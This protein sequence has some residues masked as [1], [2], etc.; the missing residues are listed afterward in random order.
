[1]LLSYFGLLEKFRLFHKRGVKNLK[2]EGIGSELFID[3]EFKN[4]I[5]VLLS[6]SLNT[7]RAQLEFKAN[8][9]A[10]EIDFD[11]LVAITNVVDEETVKEETEKK[12]IKAA[13]N[14]NRERITQFLKGTINAR[15]GKYNYQK[16]EGSDFKGTFTFFNNELVIKGSTNAMGGRVNL[17]GKGFFTRKPYV[18]AK[19][20]CRK[21]DF[22]E[23]F[24]QFEDFG[25]KVL[26]YKNIKG[27]VNGKIA[28]DVFWDENGQFL[29]E[30]LRVL[31]DISIDDGELVNF[32]MLYDFSNYVKIQ[33][34]R[35]IKF[36]NMRNWLEVKDGKVIIPSMFIQSN[37]L[38]MTVS[39]E[40][41]F[42]NAMNYNIKINAG[43]VLLNKFKKY[44][45]RLR[46]QEAKRQGWFNLYYRQS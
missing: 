40:H 31:G 26:S 34:L 38:N 16:V 3:G 32:R 4:L 46:P 18:R 17:N 45:P 5:P 27:T 6:D 8:L 33:D 19:V 44:D 9:K 7:N 42:T 22:K 43:Q 37:A 35:H 29:D 39:G 21:I 20:D 13:N 36:V 15:I 1:M 12:T 28:V 25:Q 30:D 2:I 11:R 10:D 41:S 23:L 24:R 14:I